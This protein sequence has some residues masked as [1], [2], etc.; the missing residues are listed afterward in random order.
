MSKVKSRL[1]DYLKTQDA[2]RDD[3]EEDEKDTK[4]ATTPIN[5]QRLTELA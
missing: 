3:S 4:Q 1:F 5:I 2:G